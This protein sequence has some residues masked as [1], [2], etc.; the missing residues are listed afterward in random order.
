M[1]EFLKTKIKMKEFFREKNN[2]RMTIQ[3]DNKKTS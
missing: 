1:N 2:Q 3:I